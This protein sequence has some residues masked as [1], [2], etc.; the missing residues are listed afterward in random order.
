MQISEKIRL[1]N[2]ASLESLE[3]KNESAI[4]K[5][6]TEAGLKILGAAYGFGWYKTAGKNDFNLAYVSRKMP[7]VPRNPRKTGGINAR[8]QLEAKPIFITD[9][10]TASY[11]KKDAHIHMRG[12]TAIPMIYKR[13]SYGNI[14]LC[15]KGSHNFSQQEKILC[16]ALGTGA[17]QAITINRLY[18]G[19]ENLVNVRT[20]QLKN[21][22]LKLQQDK[23]S[24]E[25]VLSSIG[26]GLIGTNKE[27][28]VIFVNP[29]AENILKIHKEQIMGG[30]LYELQPLIDTNNKPVPLETHPTFK[31]LNQGKRATTSTYCYQDTAK[32]QIPLAITATPVILKDKIIGSIQVFRDISEEREVDRVKTELISLASHQLRTPLSAINW[33]TEALIKE[34]IG[35]LKPEQ[36]KYLSQIR[37]ANKKMIRMVYDFLNVSRLELGTFTVKLSVLDAAAASREII[38][39]L[40]PLIK[41]KRINL[42]E[43]YGSGIGAIEADQKI[44]QVILQ[45]LVTNAIKYTPSGGK[46]EVG[47]KLAK[48]GTLQITVKDNGHGIPKAQQSKIFSKLF[49]ADNASRLDAEGN[50]LGLYL[51]KS[52]ID[53]CG[54]KISFTSRENKGTTFTVMLPVNYSV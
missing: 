51:V 44:L 22:N 39:G 41:E 37:D 4:I 34:E 24:D 9:V 42:K 40:N 12:V 19:L 52:F 20:T 36:K 25:A 17:A 2:Q 47:L 43:N 11:I 32:H 45:N 21:S 38:A 26:E 53:I 50:G 16:N 10:K 27:G 6:F 23:V 15:Y 18:T 28:K 54:G 35:K 49:R 14:I 30:L 8:A 31:A 13:S 33:Y 5:N 29:T 7:Y 3:A 46:I 1:I 48:P